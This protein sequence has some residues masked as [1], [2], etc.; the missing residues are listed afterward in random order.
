MLIVRLRFILLCMTDSI[1]LPAEAHQWVKSL[2]EDLDRMHCEGTIGEQL[3]N[4]AKRVFKKHQ[5]ESQIEERN[6][7][8]YC[9]ALEKWDEMYHLIDELMGEYEMTD[10]DVHRHVTRRTLH[11]KL[12][13]K[14]TV[15]LA[16]CEE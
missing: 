16:T 10:V 12:S 9:R 13:K 4:Y 8:R 5:E 2:L 3:T 7:L 14:Q 11:N 6:C 15:P 1:I